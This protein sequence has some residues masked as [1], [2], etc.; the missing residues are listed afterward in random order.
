MFDVAVV[1]YGPTGLIAASAL[2]RLGHRVVVIERWP[3]PYGLP[4]ITHV[5]D[6][7]A[8]I[9]QACG[10]VDQALRDVTPTEFAW[11][12]GRGENLFT[13]PN[14][15]E[16]RMGFPEHISIYQPDIEDAID[17]CVQS[18]PSVVVRRGWCVTGLEQDAEHVTLSLARWR[19]DARQADEQEREVV[20][21]R[22]VI[23]AGGA[24]S[25]V[26]SS[27]GIERQDLGF[28]VRWLNVDAEIKRDLGE[29]FGQAKQFCDPARRYMFMP[30]GRFRQRFEWAL[31]DDEPRELAERPEFAWQL[32]R[33]SHGL[34]P[35]DV[36]IVRQLEYTFESR[37]ART[38][39][40]GRVFLAG[41]AA[42]TQP[43]YL[44]QGA[45]SGMRDAMNLAWKLDL[46]LSERSSADVIETYEPERR[47]QLTAMTQISM[48]LGGIANLHDPDAAA[49]RDMAFQAGH[50]PPPPAIPGVLA[51]VVR[52]GGDGLP[53]GV[54]GTLT[55]Q[56]RVK[57][58][59]R[60]GRFDEL[61]G[62]GFWL[63][64]RTDPSDVLD[65]ERL[66]F[67]EQLGCTVL[68]LDGFDDLDGRYRAYLD[69]LGVDAVLTGPDFYAFGTA[70]SEADMGAMVD[71][72][73]SSVRWVGTA[74]AA[75]A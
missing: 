74:R 24:R 35:E 8:R 41:D 63:L 2:G 71:E 5:D 13:I 9:V 43:P 36:S 60:R 61:V 33:E 57:L 39:R 17:T 34:G 38:W 48:A 55:P 46:V 72:L 73:R 68:G 26:R 54:A 29:H 32:L 70:E 52:H 11:S 40:Q 65:S 30:I 53:L 56:G 59:G 51:G 25:A 12:N 62:G 64:A 27:L 16:G 69:E 14:A 75:Q 37:I 44:G 42:H 3:R 1:G 15:V 6:E 20:A 28:N 49:A 31:H 47:P 4:R 22:Y 66:G 50:A 18:L 7:T 10:D 19:A 45:C 67:L 21:A 23:A 58:A